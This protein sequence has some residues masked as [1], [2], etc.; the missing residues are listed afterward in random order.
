MSLFVT[1]QKAVPYLERASKSQLRSD[2][3]YR[4]LLASMYM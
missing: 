3:V 1:R 4:M 2:L